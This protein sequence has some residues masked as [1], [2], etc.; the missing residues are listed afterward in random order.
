ME[1]RD[2]KDLTVPQPQQRSE[3][4]WFGGTA[5]HIRLPPF[6]A[7]QEASVSAPYGVCLTFS[8]HQ[9]CIVDIGGRIARRDVPRGC[10]SISGPE[11]I[12]WL[13]AEEPSDVVE[14]VA[15][16]DIRRAVAEETG[17]LSRVELDDVHGG[18]DPV[19]WSVAS[20]FR[21]ALLRSVELSDLERDLLLHHLYHRIFLS[22]FGGRRREKG[23]GGLDERRLK[24]VVAFIDANLTSELT[25][26]GLAEVACLTR[27]HFLRSFKR[28]VG[29]TPHQFVLGRRLEQARSELNAGT[30]I[31]TVARRLGFS[32]RHHFCVM[33]Q[34]HHGLMPK[35][36]FGAN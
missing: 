33:Y 22:K 31:D 32:H 26:A 23:D 17:A 25:I 13:A 29:L 30:S 16:A 21:A 1:L 14:I 28:T 6:A 11:Q 20:R 19:I 35:V 4:T 15:S 12:V 10:I 9:R 18:L 34:R 7:P 5:N 24:R 27:F 2:G 8:S 3:M 36:R